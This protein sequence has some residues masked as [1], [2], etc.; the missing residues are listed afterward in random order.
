MEKLLGLKEIA[1]LS[2]IDQERIEK[3]SLNRSRVLTRI[4]KG[5]WPD[6][7][8]HQGN[9]LTAPR[10]YNELTVYWAA[11]F[12]HLV[13]DLGFSEIS[14]SAAMADVTK[15]MLA[16]AIAAPVGKCFT[17]QCSEHNPADE[18][19]RRQFHGVFHKFNE[20]VGSLGPYGENSHLISQTTI[21]LDSIFGV[22][23]AKLAN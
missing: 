8:V 18:S 3:R 19:Y 12:F 14:A 17:V 6:M 9:Y 16:D 13:E 1:E 22:I 11:I 10:L 2:C 7:L 23:N 21:F 15:E 5:V 4:A 20:Q